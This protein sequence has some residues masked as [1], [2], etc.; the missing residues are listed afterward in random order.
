MLPE[1]E[2]QTSPALPEIKPQQEVFWSYLDLVWL[3]GIL[4]AGFVAMSAAGTAAKLIR[5]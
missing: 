3:M 1:E 4:F 2:Q 5:P